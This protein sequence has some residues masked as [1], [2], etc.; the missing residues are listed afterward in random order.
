MSQTETNKSWPKMKLRDRRHEF[1]ITES[2]SIKK[3]RKVWTW[4]HESLDIKVRRSWHDRTKVWTWTQEILHVSAERSEK[5]DFW[6][7]IWTKNFFLWS[8]SEQETIRLFDW[9]ILLQ[10]ILWFSSLKIRNMVDNKAKKLC[11]QRTKSF[12]KKPGNFFLCHL[13]FNDNKKTQKIR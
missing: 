2:G 12:K 4:T 8:H 6:N 3:R 5:N 1:K 9:K 7:I 10:N 13:I 11:S